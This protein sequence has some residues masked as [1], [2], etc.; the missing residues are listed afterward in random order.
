MWVR[1]FRST[2]VATN[3]FRSMAPAACQELTLVWSVGQPGT[4]YLGNYAL[5]IG[6]GINTMEDECVLISCF[7]RWNLVRNVTDP[8]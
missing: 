1:N 5:P 8:L 3:Y 7:R 6:G 2:E 4:D